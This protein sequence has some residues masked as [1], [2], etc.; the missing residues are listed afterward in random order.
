[1][2]PRRGSSGW[3]AASPCPAGDEFTV[4]R[5]RFNASH[6]LSY[7]PQ[8]LVVPDFNP[9]PSIMMEPSKYP[10][11]TLSPWSWHGTQLGRMH[12]TWPGTSS[13]PSIICEC[14]F[15]GLQRLGT[16]SHL[17]SSPLNSC[18][19]SP[20]QSPTPLCITARNRGSREEPR[21][22]PRLPRTLLFGS[23]VLSLEIKSRHVEE[24]TDFSRATLNHLSGIVAMSDAVSSTPP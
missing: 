5:T 15:L 6:V 4:W 13:I 14:V 9:R 7:N 16:S 21:R 11:L 12:N 19:P 22:F 17:I 10:F 2:W 1:M 23:S 3:I 24:W 18:P 20:H 8:T